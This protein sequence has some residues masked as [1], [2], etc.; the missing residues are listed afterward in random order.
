MIN[1]DF[2]QK[3]LVVLFGIFIFRLG[4]YLPVPFVDP[5]TL[6]LYSQQKS[7]TILDIFNT[8]SG[9][10]IERFS[11]LAIGI[12]P[13]ISA[14]IIIQMGG[15]FLESLKKLKESGEEGQIK[16]NMYT[17]CLTLSFAVL[18]AVALT[19]HLSGQ[20]VNGVPLVSNPDFSFFAVAVCSLVFGTMFLLWLGEKLTEYG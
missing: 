13:Y 14:S 10:S 5:A 16:L 11:I 7:G 19:A 20:G 3:I 2:F 6:A 1:K 12:M 15:Y 9:G 8:F 18:Q 17:R 4:T